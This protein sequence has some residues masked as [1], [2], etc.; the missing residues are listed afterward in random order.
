VAVLA[1]ACSADD[2]G[3]ASSTTATTGAPGTTTTTAAPEPLRVLVTNDDG[4]AAEGIDALVEALRALPDV[5]VTVV[6]PDENKSGSGDQTTAG[7]LVTAAATTASG[8]PATAVTG[9]PADSVVWALGNG[10]EPHLVV[11]GV[12]EGQNIGPLTTI[13]GTVGAALTA[14]RRGIP[15]LAVSAGAGDP[16]DYET[17][18]EAAIDWIVEHRDALLAGT[19]DLDVTTINSPTCPTGEVRGV[20]E[21]PT[22]LDRGG[23]SLTE[24][25]C[26]STLTDPADDIDAFANGYVS[27]STLSP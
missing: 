27:L 11:S 10:A 25:D 20:V 16:V 12:N 18:I 24:V 23:R 9:F 21:V 26:A 17:G 22:A 2:G 13:S 7:D 15:A 3:G 1:A 6:A 19:A 14:A 8:Y 4:V 5:E